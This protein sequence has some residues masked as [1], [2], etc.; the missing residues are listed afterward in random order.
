MERHTI[1]IVDDEEMVLKTI[2][3]ILLDENCNI[4]TARS[5]QEG[6]AKLANHEVSMVI[7][8]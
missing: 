7:S 1:L 4:L 8:D 5:G 6:L 2:K 3:R